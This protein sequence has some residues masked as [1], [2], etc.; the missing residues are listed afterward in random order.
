MET[1]CKYVLTSRGAISSAHEVFISDAE[2]PLTLNASNGYLLY[3]EV[4]AQQIGACG[5]DP[6][7]DGQYS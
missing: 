5:E 7:L 4:V 1:G 6:I 3:D 2:R